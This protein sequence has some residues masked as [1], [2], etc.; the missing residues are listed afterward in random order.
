MSNEASNKRPHCKA[1]LFQPESFMSGVV[2]KQGKESTL[3]GLLTCSLC[4]SSNGRNFGL[5]KGVYLLVTIR[6]TLI[7]LRFK[8]SSEKQ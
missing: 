4:E 3:T 5:C 6:N 8:V 7:K 1:W 2:N